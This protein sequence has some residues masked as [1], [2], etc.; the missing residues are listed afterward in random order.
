MKIVLLGPPGVGKG[1]HGSRISEKYD[2]PLITTGDIIRDEIRRETEVGKEAKNYVENGKLVPDDVV[3][4]M[5]RKRLAQ[6]NCEEGFILDGFPRTVAQAEALEGTTD[7]D[8]VLNLG[9]PE[10]VLVNRLSS[11]RTCKDCGEV[12]NLISMPPEVPG[13]CDKCGGELF[14]REDDKPEVIKKRLEEYENQTEPLLDYYRKK[15]V[16]KDVIIEKERPVEEIVEMVFNA[17]ESADVD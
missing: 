11:R 12:Y 3:I 1:T 9:A 4:K 16:V 17:L 15:S 10:D 2:L 8:L 14:Q 7:I 13:V 5:I 6:D